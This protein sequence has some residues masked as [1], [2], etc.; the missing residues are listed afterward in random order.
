MHD[1]QL[2]ISNLAHYMITTGRW[3]RQNTTLIKILLPHRC[4]VS[5]N[6][7]SFEIAILADSEQSVC[8]RICH[9]LARAILLGFLS[10]EFKG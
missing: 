10:L 4:V 1:I 9:H 8:L 5:S 6:N 3:E 7:F 2:S